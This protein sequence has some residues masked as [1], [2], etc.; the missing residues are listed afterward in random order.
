M[1][2]SAGEL[3]VGQFVTVTVN[4]PAHPGELAVPAEAVVEDGRQSV[5]YVRPDPVR[6]EY[7]RRPVTVVRRTQSE[8]VLAG[9]SGVR[10]G[11]RVVTAGALLLRE[12]ADALPGVATH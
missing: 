8:I 3:R 7:V 12:A 10:P 6:P 5:V 9:E 2:N 11:D 4:R 1:D